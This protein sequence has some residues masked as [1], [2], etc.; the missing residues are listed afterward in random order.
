MEAVVE[1]AI[2]SPWEP[3]FLP[4]VIYAS[5]VLA[6]M[7]VL[8]FLTAWLGAKNPT[9]E[10][11]RPFESGVIPTGSARTRYPIPYYLIAAFFLIF[12]VEA[13]FIL[14]WAIAADPLGWEG[15]LQITFFIVI[16]LVSLFYIWQKGG[17]E[18]GPTA[19]RI[20]KRP[21]ILF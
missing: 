12:D 8:L 1:K 6:L 14:S 5:M 18:W 20:L 7:G 3:G 4:L 16:L 2:W 13:V 21:K 9:P 11:S 10:K 17:L 19:P 15:W